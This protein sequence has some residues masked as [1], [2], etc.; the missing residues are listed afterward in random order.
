MLTIKEVD[1]S[2]KFIARKLLTEYGAF[3]F[4]EL[5]LMA[6]NE[7][8]FKELET[9]PDKKYQKPDGAFFIAYKDDVPIGCAGLKRFQDKDCELKR[10][11]IQPGERGKGYGLMLT[12]QLLRIA[13]EMG[14]ERVLLDTNLEMPAAVQTYLKAGFVK[15]AAYCENDN[16]HPVFMQ[17]KFDKII[18]PHQ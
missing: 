5:K 7:T 10:M 2:N 8:F 4:E 9:F 11:Y 13:H 3:L 15:I 12:D 17:Y 1:E 14:F 16:L 18:S 6:G